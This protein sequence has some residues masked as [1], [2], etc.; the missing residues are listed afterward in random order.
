MRRDEISAMLRIISDGQPSL[1][2]H[3]RERTKSSD[4]R[5]S[6][7]KSSDVEEVYEGKGDDDAASFSEEAPLT[8]D[9]VTVV[10]GVLGWGDIH[11]AP[12]YLKNC[13]IEV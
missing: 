3:S 9:E 2:S 12:Y 11:C 8:A 1:R 6:S 4:V 7:L 10:T 13:S 5:F